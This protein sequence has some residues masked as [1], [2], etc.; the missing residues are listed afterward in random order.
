MGTGHV[1]D[2][3]PASKNAISRDW[4]LSSSKCQVLS[5][6]LL[7][8]LL[9]LALICILAAI[10]IPNLFGARQKAQN[11][12]TLVYGRDMLMHATAWLSDDPTRAVSDLQSDCQH[13]DYVTEGAKPVL[14]DSVSMCEVQQLGGGNYGVKITSR[15]GKMFE[16]RH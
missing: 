16:V 7:E 12:V 5:F 4:D 3:S 14:P 1:L 15:T 10:L 13:N 11:A 2:P 6:S 8:L 9:I